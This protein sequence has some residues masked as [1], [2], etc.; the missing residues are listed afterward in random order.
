MQNVSDGSR[1][2]SLEWKETHVKMD[3]TPVK[4]TNVELFL[5]LNTHLFQNHGNLNQ[6]LIENSNFC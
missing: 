1:S 2:I 5:K 6:V 4:C 3:T